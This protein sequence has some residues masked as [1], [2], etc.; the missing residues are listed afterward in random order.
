[1]FSFD[2]DGP[3]LTVTANAGAAALLA[4]EVDETVGADRYNAAIG[5][6]EDAGG[7]ANTD[8]AGPGLGQ[9]TTN[10]RGGRAV[11]SRS[12][13]TFGSGRCRQRP[14]PGR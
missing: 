10:H 9:V 8:D 4:T 6:T 13:A 7:N 3:A 5:E 12:A 11:C 2:D 1:M 14:S